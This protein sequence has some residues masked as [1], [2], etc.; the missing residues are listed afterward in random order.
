M[1][2]IFNIFSS[3]PATPSEKENAAAL[4]VIIKDHKSALKAEYKQHETEY[5]QAV[6]EADA[7]YKRSKQEAKD[8]LYR[9][10]MEA[11]SR[12]ID[13]ITA[14]DEYVNS[15]KKTKTK[16]DDFK[17]WINTETEKH[18]GE[19]DGELEVFEG[20]LDEKTSQAPAA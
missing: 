16:I 12:E 14:T 11:V 13:I 2:F 20:T 15:D 19:S 4:K 3:N 8:K 9:N 6:K 5:K 1:S 17:S 18:L 7:E 10:T